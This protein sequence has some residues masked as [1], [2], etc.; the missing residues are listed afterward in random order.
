VFWIADSI[1][2]WSRIYQSWRRFDL[3]DENEGFKFEI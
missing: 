3:Y 2:K 1:T